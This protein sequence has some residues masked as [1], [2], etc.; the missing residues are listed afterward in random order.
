MV[1]VT[2]IFILEPRIKYGVNSA[3][4]LRVEY[5]ADAT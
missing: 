4:N 1:I 2:G 5:R 3:K